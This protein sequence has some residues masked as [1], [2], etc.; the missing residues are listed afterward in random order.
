MKYT[1]KLCSAIHAII[2]DISKHTGTNTVYT[3]EIL[4]STFWGDRCGTF[5]LAIAKCN[6][7]DAEDFY[8]FLFDFALDIGVEFST[9]TDKDGKKLS[10]LNWGF[11]K[12]P[13]LKLCLKHKVCCITFVSR[14]S[15]S[16]HTHHSDSIGRG[17]NR[18]DFDDSQHRKQMLSADKHAECHNMGQS[19]FDKKYKIFGVI[20]NE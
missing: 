13:L 9:W 18:N 12:E 1:P 17:F 20:Y 8:Q 11:D 15:H 16:T 14:R 2:R 10:P 3:R 7:I 4:K 6:P 5:S 19:E